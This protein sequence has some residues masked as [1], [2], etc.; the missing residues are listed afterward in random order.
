MAA[1]RRRVVWTVGARRALDEAVGYVSEDSPARARDLLIRVLDAAA[2]LV[3]LGERGR[4]VD[5]YDDPTV[6]QLLVEPYRLLYRVR[7]DQID[8]IGLIHQR[9][10][11]DNWRRGEQ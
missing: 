9:R 6:R 1:R 10:A 4:I 3:A 2:S 7:D 11:F 5:E 8:V